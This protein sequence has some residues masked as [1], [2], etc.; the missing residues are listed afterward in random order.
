VFQ[1][2]DWLAAWH[3]H[4]G[5]RARVQPAVAVGRF[6]AATPPSCCRCAPRGPARRLCWLGQELCDYNAPLLARDF[7]ERVTA[8]RFLEIWRELRLRLQQD[9]LF[10]HDWIDL[11]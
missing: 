11:E 3:R 8:D 1:T 9:P 6:R 5:L 7:S 2:F 4:I 10:R